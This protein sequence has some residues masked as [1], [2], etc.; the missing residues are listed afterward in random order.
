MRDFW[1]L[2][3]LCKENASKQDF[4]ATLDTMGIPGPRT[5][6][7]FKAVAEHAEEQWT[8]VVSFP[9]H[10]GRVKVEVYCPYP[11]N[12]LGEREFPFRGTIGDQS[13]VLE[14]IEAGC[15][16]FFDSIREKLSAQQSLSLQ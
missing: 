8:I 5:K 6:A 3:F 15:V 12:Q 7:V 1:I 16:E 14:E 9:N 13:G 11:G 2:I 4:L 10:W